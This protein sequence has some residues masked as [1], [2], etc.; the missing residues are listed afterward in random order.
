M[1]VK[2]HLDQPWPD[3]AT[4]DPAEVE[5][6]T[7]LAE[8][9]WKPDGK[10]RAMHKFNPVRRDYIVD[11]IADHFG[12]DVSADAPFAGLAILDVGCGA[13]LLCEPLAA[14]DAHVI[15]IDATA[16]NVEIARWHAAESGLTVDYRHCLAAHVLEQGERFDVVLNTE[17]VEHVSDP[18]QLMKECSALVKP[19]GIMIVAT[20]SRTLRAFLLAIVGAEYV[21]RWLP[22]GTHDWRRFLRP[23]E[24]S[25]MVGRHGLETKDV[26]G[27]SFN[28]IADRWRLSGDTGVNYMLLAAK[29]A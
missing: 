20:L 27:V 12:R 26:T 1:L 19:G 7:A 10:F 22:K 6:F 23:D 14:H 15:G 21:L 9:W 3:A 25:A 17:V 4:V 11:R 13:G 2:D 16:R 18:E 5:R 28:P 29:G 24:I 8:E